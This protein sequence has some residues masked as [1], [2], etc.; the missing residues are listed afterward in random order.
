VIGVLGLQGDFA[1]HG[2]V[3]SRLGADWRVVK[4]PEQLDGLAG[5]IVPG[6]ESTTLIRL[7]DT[8]SLWAP[9]RVFTAGRGGVLLGTCAGMIIAARQVDNP[10][11]RSLGLIDI[12]VERNSYGRQLDSFEA[13][14]V[15]HP[16][17]AEPRPLEMVF[18]R[19]PRIVRLGPQVEPLASCRGDCV[20]A[21]QGPVMVA[22][23]HPELTTDPT[24]HQLFVAMCRRGR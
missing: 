21:R 18:I 6:G 17:Q 23:F 11:Q 19:A 3:L 9:L 7:L 12:A 22:S 24:V 4:K 16:P 10:P 15:F 20:L 13:H 1:A 8:S 5:L 2:Q 14:G